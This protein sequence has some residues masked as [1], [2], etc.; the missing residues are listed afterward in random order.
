MTHIIFAILFLIISL[1]SLI[2]FA[3]Y[4]NPNMYM[5]FWGSLIISN[6]YITKGV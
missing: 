4:H 6:I 2:M 1:S 3:I 5:A